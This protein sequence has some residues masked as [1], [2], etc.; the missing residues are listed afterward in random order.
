M[1]TQRFDIFCKVVDNFGDAGVSWRLARQLVHEHDIAVTLW[2]DAIASLA[3]V[4]P[5]VDAMRD[6][7][8]HAGVRVR[9]WKDPVARFELPDV[10]V[11]AFG[12]GLPQSYLDAMVATAPQP[13]WINLEYLS[14]E[15][16]VESAHGLPSPQPRLPL[17]RYFFFPGFTARTGGLLRE[18]GLIE[19]RERAHA[20]GRARK[21]LWTSLGMDI[22]VDGTAVSLFCYANI[23]LTCLLDAWAEGD[24]PI[25][26]VVPEGVATAALDAWTGGNVPHAKQSLT[27]GRL[28]LA[29]I[30]FLAQDD[31]DRLLWCCDVNVVRGEDS[32]VRAQW[33]ARP[34]VWHI[35]PQADDAHRVKLEEFLRRYDL[36]LDTEAAQAVN[37]FWLGFNDD[38]PDAAALA[39]P[40]YRAALPALSAHDI[41]WANRL[42]KLPDLASELVLFCTDR[43]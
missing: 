37:A 5:D 3:K 8:L 27:R 22:P 24:E 26:C 6:D 11:E 33:A 35:Y 38:R 14:A 43:L 31:Y 42:R 16:W 12:C 15:P 41:G 18:A 25:T 19:A 10:V 4:A 13:V 2:I 7:Q 32:F 21:A 30:P 1:P 36:G 23:G 17:T 40:A 9:H 28:T 39:W 29:T 34:F 20:G